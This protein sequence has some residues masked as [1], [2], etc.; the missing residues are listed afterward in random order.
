MKGRS[1]GRKACVVLE[2]KR[3]TS[4]NPEF[5]LRLSNSTSARAD[6]ESAIRLIA[7]HMAD[8]PPL[9]KAIRSLPVLK[10][11]LRISLG[12]R[13]SVASASQWETVQFVVNGRSGATVPGRIK[14]PASS[15]GACADRFRGAVSLANAP[16]DTMTP[17]TKLAPPVPSPLKT[18]GRVLT[19]SFSNFVV[20]DHPLRS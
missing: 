19:A 20:A 5:G 10:P 17:T 2:T 3:P 18:A 7:A 9:L 6:A 15:S 1:A 14:P 16:N 4:H 11:S 13:G 12:G 8:I